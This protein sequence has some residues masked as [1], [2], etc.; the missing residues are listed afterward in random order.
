MKTRFHLRT[1][2]LLGPD[3][4][5]AGA[6]VSKLK[7]W[8]HANGIRLPEAFVE[9]AQLGGE[10]VLTK[11]SNMDS[12]CFEEPRII[13]TPEGVQGLLFHTENQGN[14]QK[15][16][17]LNGSDDPPVLFGCIGK[18]PWVVHASRFSD[19]VYA[20]VFDWQYMLDDGEITYYGDIRLGTDRCVSLL[21]SRFEQTVTTRYVM[22]QR[23]TTEYRFMNSFTE[24]RSECA[25]K[26]TVRPT[27]QRHTSQS[28]DKTRLLRR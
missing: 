9:W 1:W 13:S 2:A 16:V 11:Y 5:F 21:K 19:C 14:F 3:A 17:V 6:S 24:R 10:R 7:L 15:I 23:Y 4:S 22:D 27:R 8:G 26:I 28:P 25:K 20:Q 18:P 12:F